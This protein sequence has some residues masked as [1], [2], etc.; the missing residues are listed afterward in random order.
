MG[1]SH[2]IRKL[3]SAHVS[4]AKKTKETASLMRATADVMDQV[5]TRTTTAKAVGTS[6]S[7]LGTF[8]TI[9][10]GIAA[11]GTGGAATPLFIAGLVFTLG[12]A[13][14]NGITSVVKEVLT[15]KDKEALEK[16]LQEYKEE[17]RNFLEIFD[18]L[19]SEVLKPDID[20][21]NWAG[22]K[23]ILQYAK[24]FERLYP[25]KVVAVVKTAE[26]L[27]AVSKAAVSGGVGKGIG[28]KVGEKIG[29]QFGK[30]VGI[31]V[32]K[33]VGKSA[34]RS[35]GKVMIVTG[36]FFPGLGHYRFGYDHQQPGEE[37]G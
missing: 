20:K 29:E 21:K 3:C 5:W 18:D 8:L 24:Q 27:K 35:A 6:V 7:I 31:A 34:A 13:G 23:C 28:K 12:A 11:L 22:L 2:P 4:L 14:S 15:S 26:T 36:V 17:E 32:G 25:Q 9:G 10:A 1:D 16:K 33:E 30:E 19:L 37:E